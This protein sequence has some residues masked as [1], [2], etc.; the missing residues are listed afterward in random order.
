MN[1]VIKGLI[2][3]TDQVIPLSHLAENAS[4]QDH[5]F[6]QQRWHGGVFQMRSSN[7]WET[8]KVLKSLIPTAWYLSFRRNAGSTDHIFQHFLWNLIIVKQTHGPAPF[9]AS[10]QSFFERF[11]EG[12]P[13]MIFYVQFRIPR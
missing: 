12:F 8:C 13:Y 2:R 9:S 6:Q 11:H 1:D 10:L 7:I 5:V 4:T 3:K